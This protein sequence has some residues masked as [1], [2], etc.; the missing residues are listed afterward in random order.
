MA[1]DPFDPPR[2]LR[3][4]AVALAAG[5]IFHA[6]VLASPTADGPAFG[7][8]GV[9]GLDK[10][11]HAVAY[12]GLASAFAVALVPDFEV[13]VAAGLAVLFA[14]GYGVGIEFVQLSA[15]ERAF[16]VTDMAANGT[17]ALVGTAAWRLAA[18]FTERLR[19]TSRSK[20]RT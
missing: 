12:A 9:L 14:V 5:A 10:W 1:F 17:G 18:A 4:V 3:W 7:P 11:L 6:S 13:S 20:L 16:S 15:P 19:S 2:W 8:L